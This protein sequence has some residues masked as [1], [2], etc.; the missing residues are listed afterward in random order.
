M[1]IKLALVVTYNEEFRLIKFMI[2][3]SR[4]FMKLRDKLNNI[5]VHLHKTNSHQ[6]VKVVTYCERL[7]SVYNIGFETCGQVRLHD[8]LKIW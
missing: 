4:G 8:K 1:A 7:P 5:Y 3:G 2:F 6:H